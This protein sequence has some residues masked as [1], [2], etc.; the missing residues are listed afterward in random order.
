MNFGIAGIAERYNVR[1]DPEG[2]YTGFSRVSEIMPAK[3]AAH[4]PAD[5][6]NG[7]FGENL[8]KSS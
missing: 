1:K 2:V 6:F 7:C 3:I 8:W 5:I 4:I